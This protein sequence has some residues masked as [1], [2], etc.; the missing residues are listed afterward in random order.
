MD[1]L[2]GMDAHAEMVY[3]TLV[4]RGEPVDAAT[5]SRATGLTVGV[6]RARLRLL[7]TFGLAEVVDS[8]PVRYAPLE[9]GGGLGEALAR[10]ETAIRTVMRRYD[11]LAE[12]FREAAGLRSPAH[13]VEAVTGTAAI[14]DRI[15]QLERSAES[16][17]RVFDR[18]PYHPSPK[19]GRMEEPE[20]AEV[21]LLERGVDCQVL[22]ARAAF[23]LPG[24][25]ESVYDCVRLGEEARVFS[26]LPTKLLIV[27]GRTACLPLRTGPEVSP[28][29][30]VVH[31]SRLVDVMTA[32]FETLWALAIPIRP[33]EMEE[34]SDGEAAT[35]R[36]ITLLGMGFSDR[37]IARQLGLSERTFHRRLHAV[38]TEV[39]VEGRFQ[40]GAEARR[41]GWL[42]P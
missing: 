4:D 8:R 2:E 5:L 22:Y 42:D 20:P 31:R 26:T 7:A 21:E 23:E 10:R 12:Y 38:M 14:R 13:L 6:V 39:G 3:R 1:D 32:L 17:V 27:D 34:F 24:R 37:A 15:H 40:L 16:L 36:I 25:L 19:D 9:P 33:P 29:F 35:R 18:P 41:R 30:V 11:R 28:S